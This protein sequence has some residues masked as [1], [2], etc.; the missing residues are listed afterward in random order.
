M[1]GEGGYLVVA[2]SVETGLPFE[3]FADMEPKL[4]AT[5]LRVFEDR[6]HEDKK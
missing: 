3:Y 4:L 1:T 2:L 5:Y 6:A